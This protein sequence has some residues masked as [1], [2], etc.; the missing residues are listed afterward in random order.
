MCFLLSLVLPCA[1]RAQLCDRLPGQ[2]RSELRAFAGYSP[3]SWSR[4]QD[5]SERNFVLAGITYSY[6][7]REWGSTSLS[8]TAA[9]MPAAI[10][11]QPSLTATVVSDGQLAERYRPAHSV[12]GFAVSPLGA[13][14]EIARGRR[15]HPFIEALL[16]LI[17]ST[18]PIPV[19][20]VNAT[21]LNFTVD[22]G[23]GIRWRLS[24]R[25]GLVFGYK[26]FHISNASTTSYNPGINNNVLYAGYSFFW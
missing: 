24:Q 17:A 21:G 10:L 18:E 15:V 16:G 2:P 3:N 6:L 5:V 4:T 14:L 19:P 13:T 1:G 20:A 22:V 26:W 23:G 12:Y 7:C 9:L 8:Y 11:L 25:R